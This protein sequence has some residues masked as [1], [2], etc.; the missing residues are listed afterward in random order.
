MPEEASLPVSSGRALVVGP[1]HRLI[2]ASEV[3]PLLATG[4]ADSWDHHESAVYV[5]LAESSGSGNRQHSAR[6]AISSTSENQV[7]RRRPSRPVPSAS[8]TA[9]A[10]RT[11]VRCVNGTWD[12]LA[13]GGPKGMGERQIGLS[14]S[15]WLRSGPARPA[16]PAAAK[17]ASEMTGHASFAHGPNG[18]EHR[19]ARARPAAGSTQSSEPDCPKWPK[20]AGELDCPVQ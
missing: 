1:A 4:L 20:V 10:T 14:P 5:G 7:L 12:Y 17:T 19:P 8:P 9:G 13:K 16:A 18:V 6:H 2:L 15:V 11:Y 3:S